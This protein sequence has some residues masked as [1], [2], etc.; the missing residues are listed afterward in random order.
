MK[1]NIFIT[2]INFYSSNDLLLMVILFLI[3]YQ[4]FSN[5]NDSIRTEI[6]NGKQFIIHKVD[7]GQGLLS[8]ARRYNIT[9][10]EIMN[11]NP[12]KAKKT[13]K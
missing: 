13:K 6:K 2:G 1:K 3:S 4:A 11:A 7:K 5:P 9:V 12:D 10:D 8:I